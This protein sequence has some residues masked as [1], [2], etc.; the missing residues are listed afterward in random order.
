M[1]KATTR[2][3]TPRTDDEESDDEENENFEVNIVKSI[4]H[5]G[6]EYQVDS[7]NNLRDSDGEEK[8]MI[9]DDGEVVIW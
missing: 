6:I 1:Q 7:D 2:P 4:T 5:D 3:S 9:M 8:G